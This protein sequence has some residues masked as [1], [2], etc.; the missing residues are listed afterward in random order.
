MTALLGLRAVS[1]RSATTDGWLSG[2]SHAKSVRSGSVDASAA[3]VTASTTASATIIRWF[4]T[5]HDG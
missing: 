3:P 5:T 1:S 2:R 4:R